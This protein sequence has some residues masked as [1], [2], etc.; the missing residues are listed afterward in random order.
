MKLKQLNKRRK[1]T[2]AINKVIR[3]GYSI[4]IGPIY[5]LFPYKRG[6]FHIG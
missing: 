6:N 1:I 3:K 2:L 5:D 4:R